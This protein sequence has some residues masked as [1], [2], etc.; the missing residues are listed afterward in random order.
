MVVLIAHRGNTDG[1][2]PEMENK[3]EY[4]LQAIEK[5]FYVEIDVW[6]LDQ[7]R[8]F[9]GHDEPEYEIHASFLLNNKDKIICHAK[10]PETLQF[11]CGSDLHCFFHDTDDCTLTSKKYIWT[12]PGKYLTLRSICVMPEWNENGIKCIKNEYECIGEEQG[13]KGCAGEECYGIC[14][15][16]VSEIKQLLVPTLK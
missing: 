6:L 12:Y 15:D 10:T 16:F 2:N 9:L 11:L 13:I 4:I 5:G 8:V 1:R 14:S 7:G 3:P